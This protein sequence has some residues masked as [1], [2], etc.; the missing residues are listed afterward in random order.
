MKVREAIVLLLAAALLASA[1]GC[2]G[3]G[4]MSLAEYRESMLALQEE[5]LGALRT[6]LEELQAVDL[7]DLFDLSELREALEGQKAIMGEASRKAIAM[8]TPPEVEDLHKELLRYYS[9]AE[10]ALGRMANSAGFFQAVLPMLTDARN[11]ALP[12]IPADSQD[13]R[14]GAASEEDA[15]TMHGYVKRLK[16]IV[17]PE[18]LEPYRDKLAAFFASVEEKVAGVERAVTRGDKGALIGFQEEFPQLRREV[19]VMQGEIAVYRCLFL[20]RVEDL[21]EKGGEY[22]ERIGRL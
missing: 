3:S 19:D 1:C 21:M 22:T 2:A 11:L 18:E 12:G 8:N 6:S 5:A 20:L 16:G 15:A 7:G 14:I 9:R 13:A 17:P 4:V 10:R